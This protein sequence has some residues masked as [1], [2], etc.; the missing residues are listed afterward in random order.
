M[1]EEGTCNGWHLLIAL[2]MGAVGYQGDFL[3]SFLLCTAVDSLAS[4]CVIETDKR[5]GI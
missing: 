5:Q 3:V 4:H 1:K 2:V